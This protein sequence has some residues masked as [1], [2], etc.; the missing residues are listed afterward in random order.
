MKATY[1]VI[2]TETTEGKTPYLIY[3]PDLDIFTQGENFENA[4]TMAEDLICLHCEMLEDNGSAIPAPSKPSEISLDT[5]KSPFSDIKDATHTLVLIS[6]DTDLY[7][8]KMSRRSVRR[9]VT[10][11][12]WL[13]AAARKAKLNVSAIL[14]EALQKELGVSGH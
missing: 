9:N 1:P 3:V 4:K 5:P 10:L 8:K 13:D 6:I 7:R 11:P 14:Q 12:A 2:F